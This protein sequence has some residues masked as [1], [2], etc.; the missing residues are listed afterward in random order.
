MA[1]NLSSPTKKLCHHS[2]MMLL[3]VIFMYRKRLLK[4]IWFELPFDFNELY[5]RWR[6]TFRHYL[7]LIC[8]HLLLTDFFM[9]NREKNWA[10]P[11]K[12]QLF[13]F[14]LLLNCACVKI[15]SFSLSKVACWNKIFSQLSVGMQGLPYF[16]TKELAFKKMKL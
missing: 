10:E 3:N 15:A 9:D 7:F 1:R 4:Y 8:F 16:F 11:L 13:R 2:C 6:W 12:L 5:W 14:L